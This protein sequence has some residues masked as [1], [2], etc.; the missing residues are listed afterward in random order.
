M[1][2]LVKC[3]ERC[4]ALTKFVELELEIQYLEKSFSIPKEIQCLKVYYNLT[5]F[6][7]CFHNRGG[8]ETKVQVSTQTNP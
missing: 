8:D 6:C 3:G 5:F 2:Q 4:R 7:C 1:Q